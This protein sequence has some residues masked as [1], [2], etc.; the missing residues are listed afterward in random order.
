MA[1]ELGTK[2]LSELWGRGT[3]HGL[4]FLLPEMAQDRKTWSEEGKF[5]T[6]PIARRRVSV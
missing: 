5:Q 3:Y 2:G 6:T 4:H 1:A